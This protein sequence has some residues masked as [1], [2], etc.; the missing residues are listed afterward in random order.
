MRGNAGWGQDL[1][2]GVSKSTSFGDEHS[3][4]VSDLLTGIELGE[5]FIETFRVRFIVRSRYFFLYTLSVQLPIP[6]AE[7]YSPAPVTGLS[8][9][10]SP[11]KVWGQKRESGMRN[12]IEIFPQE[13]YVPIN[14]DCAHP[15]NPGTTP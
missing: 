1:G 6:T 4:D 15:H 13:N 2:E 8:L 5:L 14:G 12:S 11:K 9:L 7:R 10:E 3:R